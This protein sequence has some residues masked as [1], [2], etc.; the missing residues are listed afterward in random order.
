MTV[1]CTPANVVAMKVI[2]CCEAAF[3][4]NRGDCG[5]FLKA[6]IGG[7]LTDG[8]LDVGDADA[9]VGKLKSE[10]TPTRDI[11]TAIAAAQSGQLVVAGM[12]AAE[13]GQHHGHVAV[14]VGCDGQVS[15]SVRV[16]IGYAGSLG[17]P[18]A[19]I[20]G[21]RLSGTFLASMVQDQEIDY[22]LRTPDRVPA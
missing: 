2:A 21:A 14:V 9:I 22:F 16:P 1:P 7:F 19:Q 3:P 6:A 18:A 12:T 13:L 4:A 15:G 11:P 10:W 17:N 5:Q 20:A 8:Y